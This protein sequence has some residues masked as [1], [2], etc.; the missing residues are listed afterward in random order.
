MDKDARCDA[1][2]R[3][4]DTS[5]PCLSHHAGWQHKFRTEWADARECPH[6]DP[7]WPHQ[8]PTKSHR[9]SLGKTHPRCVNVVRKGPPCL[10]CNCLHHITNRVVGVDD[11]STMQ[12]TQGVA[13]ISGVGVLIVIPAASTYSCLGQLTQRKAR[14]QL[15]D[16]APTRP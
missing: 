15:D 10:S 9:W 2:A 5:S 1:L 8:C 14:P 7:W 12:A 13:G 6:V 11:S 16:G 3:H 4:R